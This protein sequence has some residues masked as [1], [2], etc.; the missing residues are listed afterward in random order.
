M[1]HHPSRYLLG[2]FAVGGLPYGPA[3]TVSAHLDGCARCRAQVEEIEDAEGQL[4]ESMPQSQ[5]SPMALADAM[6]RIDAEREAPARPVRPRLDGSLPPSLRRVRFRP[7]RF[8]RADTWVA[9]VDAPREDSWR[10]YLVHAP[11][12]AT[13]PKHGHPGGELVAVLHGA[14][15]DGVRY[16][17]GDFAEDLEPFE[18]DLRV[19]DDQPCICLIST[20]GRLTWRG[21]SRLIGLALDV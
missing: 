3:L 4:L 6:A 18:H 9:H 2:S 8:L 13:F 19:G 20:K 16:E 17:A 14:F 15:Q 5:L 1:N 21:A 10:T 12:G 7:R 11:A